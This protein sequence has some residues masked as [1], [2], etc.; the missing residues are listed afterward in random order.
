MSDTATT[1]EHTSGFHD[2]TVNFQYKAR[3]FEMIFSSKEELL[4]LYNAVNG[5]HY[6]D[7]ELLEINT[8][9]NAIY[10]S[11]HNDISFIIDTRLYL[12]EHQSTYNPNL[13]YRFLEY[14][15]E[16]YSKMALGK[17]IYGRTRILLPTPRFIVFYNGR[18]ELDDVLEMR[19][20]DQYTV[21]EEEPQLELKAMMIN[22]NRGRNEPLMNA[23]RTLK[24]Y[25]EYTARVREYASSMSISGA[26]EKAVT[27]CIDEGI[28]SSFLS[29]YRAEV[30]KVSIYE[31]DAEEHMRMEKEESY[32][33]GLS[34]GLEKGR[35][36]GL[37]E[38]LE[39]G[40]ASGLAEGLASG[41]NRMAELVGL[42]ADAGRF[43]DIK[44]AVADEVC[45]DSLFN[46]FGL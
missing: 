8:L 30:V 5:S 38:G 13:P 40:H 24:D 9:E 3:L 36:S 28:L 7:P 1:S 39:K 20:S 43:D 23:C 33:S 21:R 11:M 17:N 27:E 6:D 32:S 2:A 46:E 45:R 35:A 22:I 16:L 44:K 26:V 25:A 42:L 19:L 12:Y 4:G 34:E 37:A 14:I 15:S 31:Y 41:E 29:T 10:M 18:E